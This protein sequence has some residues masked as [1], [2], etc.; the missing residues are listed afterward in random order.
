MDLAAPSAGYCKFVEP[1]PQPDGGGCRGEQIPGVGIRIERSGHFL[2]F[3][4]IDLSTPT[5]GIKHGEAPESLVPDTHEEDPGNI[6]TEHIEADSFR[7]GAVEEGI[8]NRE[9][10]DAC[11][12]ELEIHGVRMQRDFLDPSDAELDEDQLIEMGEET[13]HASGP[14]DV[15]SSRQVRDPG[16]DPMSGR[17]DAG[18]R[19]LGIG[20]GPSVGSEGEGRIH[21]IPEPIEFGEGGAVSGGPVDHGVAWGHRS[22][23][24]E[25]LNE[26][27]VWVWIEAFSPRRP[28]NA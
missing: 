1:P 4:T 16:S 14:V 20:F 28:P 26:R 23:Q 13:I 24:V 3:S 6:E 8:R 15:A 18:L 7:D 11:K 25:S 2:K 12:D 19:V 9:T 21:E 10:R 17:V 22:I 5:A 27:P